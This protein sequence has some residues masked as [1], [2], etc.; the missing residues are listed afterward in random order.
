MLEYKGYH[1]SITFDYEDN[2]FC[3]TVVAVKDCLGFHGLSV[4]EL[5]ESFHNTI[6]DYLELCKKEGR[7]PDKEYKGSFNVRINPELH[8]KA[9][10]CAVAKHIS[11]NQFVAEAIERAII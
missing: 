7:E 8:R 11:L 9:A 5:V 3:G 6:D 2:I 10:L 4:D 1:A